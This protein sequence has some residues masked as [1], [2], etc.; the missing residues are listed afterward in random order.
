MKIGTIGSG[1]IVDGF[2]QS[3][4]LVDGVE[5]IASY[6]RTLSK[7][8]EFSDRYEMKYA[9]DNL[10]EMFNNSEIDTIYIASPNSLPYSQALEAIDHN[11][12]V[13]V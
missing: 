7:A 13:I 12:N 5:F 4:V 3:A 10:E 8:Q 6:S 9:Y 1:V 2:I 11:K